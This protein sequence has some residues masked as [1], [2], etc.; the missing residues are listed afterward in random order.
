MGC[1]E[2]MCIS[3]IYVLHWSWE[4]G[5]ENVNIALLFEPYTAMLVLVLAQRESVRPILPNSLDTEY[6]TLYT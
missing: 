3:F 2:M 5:R 4:R 6:Q 1:D